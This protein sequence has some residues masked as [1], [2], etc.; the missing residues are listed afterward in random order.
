VLA[1][2]RGL[3]GRPRKWRGASCS[4]GGLLA[5]VDVSLR[6]EA[7]NVVAQYLLDTRTSDFLNPSSSAINFPPKIESSAEVYF[8]IA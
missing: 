6:P 2:A 1:R 5:W 7:I 4:S 8:C 3:L